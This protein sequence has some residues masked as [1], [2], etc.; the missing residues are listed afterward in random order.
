MFSV[1]LAP[2]ASIVGQSF[3]ETKFSHCPGVPLNLPRTG[4]GMLPV[5]VTVTALG[6]LVVLTL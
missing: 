6:A 1:Q 4:C 3:V 5:L 2:T